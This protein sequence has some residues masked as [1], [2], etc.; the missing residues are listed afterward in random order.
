M[1]RV[2]KFLKVFG[3]VT[4]FVAILTALV[5]G[6]AW[7][8]SG[9][10]LRGHFGASINVPSVFSL[11]FGDV[12]STDVYLAKNGA[13]VL[14]VSGNIGGGGSTANT[15]TAPAGPFAWGQVA[16]SGGTATVTFAKPF[17]VK[18]ACVANDQTA[19]NAV[20]V[21]PNANG[22]TLVLNGT[23]TDTVMWACFGNPN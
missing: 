4:F 11:I 7:S 2:G 10:M 18:P 21:Q 22:Q 23:T 17:A 19:T 16:L 13:N 6:P 15:T 1:K 8:Q 20:G 3:V 9:G 5:V 14:G 12:T